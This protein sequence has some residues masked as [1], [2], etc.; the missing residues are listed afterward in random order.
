MGY[1]ASR[2]ALE[3]EDD[4]NRATGY[5]PF[6]MVYNSEVVL[7]INLDYRAPRSGHTMSREPRCPSRTPW[8]SLMKHATLPS[9]SRPSTNKRYT[10][11]TAT[12]CVVGPSMSGIWCSA[13]S[14]ATRT[15]ISSL[16]RGRD[17]T[18]SRRCFDRA[19]T[20]SRPS[21]IK[22]LPM[23]GTSSSYIAFTP[24]LCTNL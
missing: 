10:S 2:G 22:F 12:V 5:T 6:F 24:S 8:I 18:L 4:P 20:S 11:T 21:T 15:A 14:R 1:G 13:S 3:L 7:M 9:S 23:P 19:P 16:R 17:L